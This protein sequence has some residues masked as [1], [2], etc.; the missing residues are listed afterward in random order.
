ML[1]AVLCYVLAICVAFY[2]SLLLLLELLL[3]FFVYELQ[4]TLIYGDSYE[5]K[6]I[7]TNCGLMYDLWIT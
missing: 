4:E 5:E 2:S 1:F 3:P 6:I 7:R